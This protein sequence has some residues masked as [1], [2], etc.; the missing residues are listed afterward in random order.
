MMTRVLTRGIAALFFLAISHTAPAA[1][2]TFDGLCTDCVIADRTFAGPVT[3]FLELDLE[4]DF[5][6]K[7]GNAR[8][9]FLGFSYSGSNLVTPVAFGLDEVATARNFVLT[10]LRIAE[11]GIITSMNLRLLKTAAPLWNCTEA[12]AGVAANSGACRNTGSVVFTINEDAW[13]FG[14]PAK[15][16]GTP[17][18]QT[19]VPEPT[20]VLLVGTLCLLIAGRAAATR[21]SELQ[22]SRTA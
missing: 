10:N 14:A 1:L 16:V 21:A 18:A 9:V 17:A 2:F 3:A 4:E 8:D 15:D 11:N 19:A 13:A 6:G 7:L 12:G 22:P 5:E 20:T